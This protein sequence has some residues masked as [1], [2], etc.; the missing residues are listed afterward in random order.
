MLKCIPPKDVEV[1][2][3]NIN[4]ALFVNRVSADDQV[5][6]RSLGWTPI[7]YDPC[8]YKK[9]KFGHKTEMLRECH[10]MV[11]VMLSQA[12]EG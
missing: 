8:P 7:Q 2:T 9:R 6:M 12:N 4:V 5:K 11:E 3:P 1:L 10:I